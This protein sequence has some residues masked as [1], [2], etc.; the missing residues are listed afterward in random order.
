MDSMLLAN[1]LPR[2]GFTQEQTS[3]Y[4]FVQLRD[5][6]TGYWCCKI[7]QRPYKQM[8]GRGYSNLIQHLHAQHPTY[9]NQLEAAAP[10]ETGSIRSWVSHKAQMRFA[11]I[12]WIVEENLHFAFCEKAATRRNTTLAP[13]SVTTIRENILRLN[14]V[15]E[16]KVAEELPDQ[17]AII[18]DG[19][20]HNSEHYLAM[21]ASYE[22]NGV[23]HTPLLSFAPVIDEP[24]DDHSAETHRIAIA[25]ALA[26]FGK[27]LGAEYESDLDALQ[28]LMIKL[29]TLK[30]AAKLRFKTS[31]RPVLRQDTRWSSTFQMVNRFF[32]LVIQLDRDDDALA[33]LLPSPAATKRLKVLLTDLKRVESVSKKV[34]GATVS[35]WEVR[36]LFDALVGYFPRLAQYLDPAATI[37]CD[38]IF[39]SA[40]VKIQAGRVM[41]RAE[42]TAVRSFKAVDPA[43]STSDDDDGFADRVLKRARVAGQA[44]HYPLLINAAPP[45]SNQVERLFSMARV[46]IGMERHSLQPIS[47]ESILFL[48]YNSSYWNVHTV[49]ECLEE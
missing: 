20:S 45:T 42:K 22:I 14:A 13:V 1:P 33:D 17:F 30:Q 49:H 10:A 37:V 16:G 43:R 27:R 28:K 35:L 12:Q 2:P 36:A 47:I 18:F 23:V 48:K 31:L 15:V 44:D 9:E 39:E 32:Q 41:S 8:E 40:V 4:F 21:F 29:R 25:A 3:R 5:D 24:D 6:I 26:M 38:P 7:C 11:W 19:W 34:Q 46:V